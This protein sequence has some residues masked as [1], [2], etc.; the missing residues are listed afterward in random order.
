LKARL[1]A[2]V[3]LLYAALFFDLGVSLPF[4]PLWLRSQDLDEEIATGGHQ[5]AQ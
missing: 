5:P 4:F 2:P 3:G 1:V